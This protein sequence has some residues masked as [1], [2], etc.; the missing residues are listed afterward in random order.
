LIARRCS[1]RTSQQ[2]LPLAP[3]GRGK[4]RSQA[5]NADAEDGKVGLQPRPSAA[6]CRLSAAASMDTVLCPGGKKP[7]KSRR[8]AGQ[9]PHGWRVEGHG[10]SS[11]RHQA[12]QNQGGLLQGA[13]WF[14]GVTIFRQCVRGGS[15]LWWRLCTDPVL[16]WWT[17]VRA[18]GGVLRPADWSLLKY[19]EN[20]ML[21]SVGLGHRERRRSMRRQR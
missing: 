20:L 15:A 14:L 13:R 6:T 10:S 4:R 3:K 18:A 7:S 9:P 5:K 1:R 17:L 21:S 8:P 19:S 11:R 12:T 2:S 16:Y